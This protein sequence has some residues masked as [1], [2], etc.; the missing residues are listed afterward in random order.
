MSNSES[1]F[2]QSSIPMSNSESMFGMPAIYCRKP[3]L[4]LANLF[5]LY[6]SDCLRSNH[7]NYFTC[8]V[9]HI[10]TQPSLTGICNNNVGCLNM[11]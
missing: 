3:S 5:L 7:F 6:I 2:G 10:T 1:M 11:A 9:T 4:L 8:T